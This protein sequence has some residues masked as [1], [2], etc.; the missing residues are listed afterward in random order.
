MDGPNHPTLFFYWVQNDSLQ[1]PAGMKEDLSFQTLSTSG[2]VLS[3]PWDYIIR[4]SY[5]NQLCFCY[6]L[7]KPAG[8]SGL[9]PS[10]QGLSMLPTPAIYL[11][12]RPSRLKKT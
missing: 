11:T 4:N 10:G 6:D 12:D 5:Q 7:R 8:D 3:H 2:D 9:N 1:N